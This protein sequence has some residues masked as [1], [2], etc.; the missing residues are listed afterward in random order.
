MIYNCL[1]QPSRQA[2]YICR[3]HKWTRQKRRLKCNQP[4]LEKIMVPLVPLFSTW[5]II[6]YLIGAILT[7]RVGVTLPRLRDTSPSLYTGELGGIASP[8]NIWTQPQAIWQCVRGATWWPNLKLMQMAQPGGQTCKY[9]HWQLEP[10][11]EALIGGQNWNQ[12]MFW[13]PNL[14][15]IR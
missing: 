7:V 9:C 8:G 12:C 6:D 11:Q 4:L 3:W 13:L 2:G 1:R 10:I 14:Q 15:P 5:N